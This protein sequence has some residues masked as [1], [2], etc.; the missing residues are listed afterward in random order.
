MQHILG[1]IRM[2]IAGR[3]IRTFSHAPGQP[4]PLAVARPRE[5]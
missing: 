3:P 5:F 1:H 4:G 2:I